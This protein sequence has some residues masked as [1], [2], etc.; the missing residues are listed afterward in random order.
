MTAEETAQV[1]AYI[2]KL[3]VQHAYELQNEQ[4]FR[5]LAQADALKM[6]IAVHEIWK[7]A[8]TQSTLP[9]AHFATCV[10][11]IINYYCPD[12]DIPF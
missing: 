5:K 2:Q 4:R 1:N 12:F 9:P 6:G 8:H 10:R 3:N 7:L 11:Q